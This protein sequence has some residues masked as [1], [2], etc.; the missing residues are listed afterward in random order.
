MHFGLLSRAGNYIEAL[1]AADTAASHHDKLKGADFTI[2]GNDESVD[3][4]M[5]V[6]LG[7]QFKA[8]MYSQI[9]KDTTAK[10][11]LGESAPTLADVITA[12]EIAV[13]TAPLNTSSE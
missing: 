3:F 4:R 12:Y 11:A 10:E 9:N 6:P 7:Y 8:D 5:L 13:N 1:S 2:N